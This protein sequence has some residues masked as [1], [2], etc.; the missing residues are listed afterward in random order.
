MRSLRQT[1]TLDGDR[2]A[3]SFLGGVVSASVY[4]STRWRCG[5]RGSV[6]YSVALRS[7]RVSSLL[8]LLRRRGNG[9]CRLGFRGTVEGRAADGRRQTHLHDTRRATHHLEIRF[10][11]PPH[12]IPTPLPFTPNCSPACLAHPPESLHLHKYC[13]LTIANASQLAHSIVSQ[14]TTT[15]SALSIR[16]E[17][18]FLMSAFMP[19]FV[20]VHCLVPF[21]WR[22]WVI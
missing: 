10:A 16:P 12:S 19:S 20:F 5:R 1:R 9:G 15:H 8:V 4:A 7:V 14:H 21:C 3:R 2:R 11:P 6:L 22:A 17:L 13:L 18:V